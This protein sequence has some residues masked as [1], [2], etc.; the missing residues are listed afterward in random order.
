M[1]QDKKMILG[2]LGIVALI[3]VVTLLSNQCTEPTDAS[4]REPIPC[5]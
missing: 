3:A 1:S 2:V 4:G 5:P